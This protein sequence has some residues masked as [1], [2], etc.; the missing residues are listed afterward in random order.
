[1]NYELTQHAKDALA[2]RKILI[3]WMERALTSPQRTEPDTNDANLEHRLAVI[4][5]HGNRVLRV[6]VNVQAMP[7]SR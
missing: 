7:A 1:M 3:E 5:E 2:K 4:T 6:V